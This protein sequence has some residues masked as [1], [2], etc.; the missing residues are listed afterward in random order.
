MGSITEQQ[1]DDWWDW[2]LGEERCTWFA[3]TKKKKKKKKI[4]FCLFYFIFIINNVNGEWN[5]CYVSNSGRKKERKKTEY[6]Q[7]L[8]ELNSSKLVTWAL[9]VAASTENAYTFESRRLDGRL[10][11]LLLSVFHNCRKFWAIPNFDS[12][13]FIVCFASMVMVAI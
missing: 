7:L 2:I 13:F 4:E 5:S 1:D 9:A 6:Y 8:A 10:L 3:A 11:L 12:S